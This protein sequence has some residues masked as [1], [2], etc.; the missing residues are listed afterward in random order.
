VVSSKNSR[1]RSVKDNFRDRKEQKHE[2]DRMYGNVKVQLKLLDDLKELN[3][4]VS[5]NKLHANV[6]H[7]AYLQELIRST[8]E[9]AKFLD[10]MGDL[11]AP[12]SP[13]DESWGTDYLEDDQFSRKAAWKQAMRI[14]LY[15]YYVDTKAFG[16]LDDPR[17]LIARGAPDYDTIAHSRDPFNT[18]R[19]LKPK[20]AARQASAAINPIRV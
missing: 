19:T 20:Q 6:D 7:Y 16:V 5:R 10:S 17:S 11:G 14:P 13:P 4:K 8:G 2:M 1:E 15:Q 12:D 3:R 18:Y 9:G